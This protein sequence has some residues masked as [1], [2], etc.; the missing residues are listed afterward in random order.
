MENLV[1]GVEARSCPTSVMSVP[2]RVV[3]TLQSALPLAASPG[4]GRRW[5]RAGWRSGRAG[6]RAAPAAP[7]RAASTRAPACR[8]SDRTADTA[9]GSRPRGSRP[10]R[11]SHGR[12]KGEVI[13]DEVHLVAPVGERETQLGRHGAGAAVGGVAGDSDFHGVGRENGSIKGNMSPSQK[14]FTDG[15]APILLP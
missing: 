9:I 7:P 12:R 15:D 11:R 14:W 8:G 1:I 2:C 13:G 3:I 10:A 6:G 5:W 4:P